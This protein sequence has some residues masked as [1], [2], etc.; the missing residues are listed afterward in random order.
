M[1]KE[2]KKRIISFRVNE[3]EYEVLSKLKGKNRSV[4]IRQ[5]LMEKSKNQNKKNKN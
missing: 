2:N 3:S 4:I 5:F 1:K